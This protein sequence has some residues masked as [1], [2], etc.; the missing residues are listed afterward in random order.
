MLN[1]RLWL[2]ALKRLKVLKGKK[3][4]AIPVTGREGP[5][6]CETFRVPHYLDN[7]LTDGSK[8]VSLTRRRP[9]TFQEIPGTYFCY[10]LSRPQGHNAAGRIR[11]IEKYPPHRDSNP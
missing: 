6:G 7:W 4:K 1:G 3:R 9:F 10:R 8:V 11:S 5:Q 2:Y